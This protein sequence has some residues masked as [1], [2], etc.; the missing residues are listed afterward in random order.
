MGKEVKGARFVQFVKGK[1]ISRLDPGLL[2]PC[3]GQTDHV[4]KGSLI[5]QT[6]GVTRSKKS[7]SCLNLGQTKCGF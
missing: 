2:T 3:S 5:S 6:N 7:W 1:L 4:T